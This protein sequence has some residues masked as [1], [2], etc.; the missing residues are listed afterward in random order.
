[1]KYILLQRP[2]NSLGKGWTNH[3]QFHL[4]FTDDNRLQNHIALQD[5]Q[6]IFAF[7]I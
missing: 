1:M 6:L 2:V 4:F 7:Q 3:S 5:F